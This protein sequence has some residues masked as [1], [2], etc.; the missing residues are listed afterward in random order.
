MPYSSYFLWVDG[1]QVG[2]FPEWF[3]LQRSFAAKG[4]TLEFTIL[5]V[6]ARQ[7]R[8]VKVV[9]ISARQICVFGFFNFQ[10][11]SGASVFL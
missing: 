1:Q 6:I 10:P 8:D 3:L 11:F 9:E 7:T 4:T 5:A 2:F